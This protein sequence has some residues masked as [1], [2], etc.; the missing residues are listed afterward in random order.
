MT[1]PSLHLAGLETEASLVHTPLFDDIATKLSFTVAH[2]GTM[3]V[4]GE[5]G[6]GKRVALLSTLAQQKLPYHYVTPSFAA[7]SEKEVIRDLYQAIHADRDEFALRDMQDDLVDTLSG[8]P[9]IIVFT[10][11]DELSS[12]AASQLHFLHTRPNATWTLV[13]LGGPEVARVMATSAALRGDV[14][15][16]SEATRLRGDDLLRTVRGMHPLFAMADDRLLTAI[17]QQLCDGLLKNWATFLQMALWLRKAA[18]D[19]GQG[20]PVL[21][22]QFARAI[23][24]SLPQ[25]RIKK[26]KH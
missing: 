6:T 24:E 22:V 7:P 12:K 17:D 9:R 3:L 11:A 21:D 20:E 19:A 2:H 23:T 8:Q 25:L 14:I 13:L 16:V 5:H 15:A 18:V 10:A 26:K 1:T 4:T